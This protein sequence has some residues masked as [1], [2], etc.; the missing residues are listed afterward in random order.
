MKFQSLTPSNKTIV[1]QREQTRCVD[2][3]LTKKNKQELMD[4]TL[5][6]VLQSSI[7]IKTV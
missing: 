6:E 7:K 2:M 5:F 1:S 3:S 4:L